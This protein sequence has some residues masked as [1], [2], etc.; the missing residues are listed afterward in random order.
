MKRPPS[1]LPPLPAKLPLPDAEAIRQLALCVSTSHGRA[2]AHRLADYYERL[3]S[4][5]EH[6]AGAARAAL[7]MLREALEEVEC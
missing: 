1:K 2:E 3:L 7:G 6:N 4:I 5:N